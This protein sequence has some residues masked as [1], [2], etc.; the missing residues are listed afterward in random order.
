MKVFFQVCFLDYT[1]P[2]LL[3]ETARNEQDAEEVEVDE[4]LIDQSGEIDWQQL[5]TKTKR[6]ITHLFASL[7][8]S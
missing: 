3:E 1:S 2:I 6:Q 8:P 7:P 5:E 4:R